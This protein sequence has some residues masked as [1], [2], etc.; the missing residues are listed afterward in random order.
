MSLNVPVPPDRVHKTQQEQQG[1]LSL[2]PVAS[3]AGRDQ[4]TAG[5]SALP[6]GNDNDSPLPW[7]ITSTYH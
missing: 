1:L 4:G 6:Q 3:L 7:P 5:P 2:S